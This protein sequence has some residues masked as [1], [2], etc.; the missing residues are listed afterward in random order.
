[1][2]ESENSSK[3][4]GVKILK[5]IGVA[6]AIISL[7]LG[8]RQIVNMVRE[9]MAEKTRARALNAEAQRFVAAGDYSRAWQSIAEAA[10]LQP[11][12][13]EAQLTI[14]MEWLRNVHLAPNRGERTF[15]EITEKLLPALYEAIDTSRKSHAAT[16]L[17]H[18]GWAN[19]LMFKEGDRRVKVDDQFRS[20]LRLDTTNLYAHAMYGFWILYPGHGI[21]SVDEA[22]R[23]FESALRGGGDTNYVRRLAIAA[24]SNA[25]SPGSQAQ[26]ISLAN[27]MRK[28]HETLEF[29]DRQ[30]IATSAYFMYRNE[31]M[32]EVARL[33]TA[34]DHWETFEY[35]TEGIDFN[36]NPYLKEA[37]A[38]LKDAGGK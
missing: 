7:V 11:V 29:A 1:M 21:G 15:T 26:I 18:I 13:R 28:N 23:H 30:R 12:H 37:Y 17:A 20:A 35:L 4:L 6:T 8:T 14:A 22:N 9:S 10:R 19:Y 38:K 25:S 5:W 2:A 3:S 24:F 33:I 27:R 31:I 16:V 36:A 32:D 34:K